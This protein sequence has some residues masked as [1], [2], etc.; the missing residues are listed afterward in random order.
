MNSR[1]PT[2]HAKSVVW[3]ISEAAPLGEWV[4]KCAPVPR[5][6]TDPPEI[7]LGRWISS[8]DRIEGV[9]ISENVDTVPAELFDELFP[10]DPDPCRGA[11]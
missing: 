10:A 4:D 8:Y 1:K 5:P 7:S 2:T 9:S 6:A 3:R 11:P